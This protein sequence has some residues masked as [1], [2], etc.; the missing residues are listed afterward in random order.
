VLDGDGKEHTQDT[1]EDKV[2]MRKVAGETLVLLKNQNATLPLQAH[3]LKKLAIVG[4]N[5]KALVYSGGGSASLKPS[6]FV[7]PYDGI[8]KAL[9]KSV[10]LTYSEGARGQFSTYDLPNTRLQAEYSFLDDA[11]P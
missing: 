7:S 5:A 3:N 1:E 8:V 6:Y 9:P 4:G 11:L 10:Q 2:L